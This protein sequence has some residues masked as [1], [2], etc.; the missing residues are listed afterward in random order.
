MSKTRL[1]MIDKAFQKMDKTGNGIITVEDLKLNYSVKQHPEY[2]SGE[3]TEDQLLKKFLDVFQA[4]NTDDKVL[5]VQL[6]RPT[7]VAVVVEGR[8]YAAYNERYSCRTEPPTYS[9]TI[10]YLDAVTVY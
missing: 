9:C 7:V 2:L 8:S 3:K 5:Y 1:D 6:R 10:I 4:G